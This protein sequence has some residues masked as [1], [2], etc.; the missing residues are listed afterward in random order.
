MN[1]M[2]ELKICLTVYDDID[3]VCITETHLKSSVSDAEIDIEGYKLL[4][5]DRNFNINSNDILI[6]NSGV[7]FSSGGGCIIYYRN[8]L[9]VKIVENF[10]GAPDSSALEFESYKG[11]FYLA[12]IYRSP[13]LN[14][15]LNRILLSSINDI[16]KAANTYETI[17]V[18]DFN[19]AD[20]SWETG[21]VKYSD[22]TTNDSLL[23]QREYMDL[24]NELG[25][26]WLLTN[27]TTRRRL[28]NGVL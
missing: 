11:R 10:S 16:C 28:V 15:Q 17:L 6:K 3:I 21:I 4:R 5:K 2:D 26:M 27:E 13:N 18:G 20:V 14:I 25:M 7:H 24:F 8:N 19:L 12:C 23:L 9:N 22:L 1:K